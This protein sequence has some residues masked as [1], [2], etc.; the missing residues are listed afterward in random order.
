MICEWY[1]ICYGMIRLTKWYEYDMLC[2]WYDICYDTICLTIRCILWYALWYDTFTVWHDMLGD[3]I[4]LWYDTCDMI[5]Y[6]ICMTCNKMF[7]HDTQPGNYIKKKYDNEMIQRKILEGL[8]YMI[9]KKK[10]VGIS[11]IIV[12]TCIEKYPFFTI[13]R[14]RM[15]RV[16]KKI[17]MVIIMLRRL[18]RKMIVMFIIMFNS[19]ARKWSLCLF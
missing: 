9:M 3:T 1:D 6:M 14:T 19:Q 12:S 16:R 17:V 11:C 10:N 8:S 4:C 15:L 7:R 2:E 18:G 13:V 5:R